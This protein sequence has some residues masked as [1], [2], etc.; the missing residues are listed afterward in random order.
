MA[1]CDLRLVVTV[2]CHSTVNSQRSQGRQMTNN[3][4][5]GVPGLD[6]GLIVSVGSHSDPKCKVP[7]LSHRSKTFE[8]VKVKRTRPRT[9]K[10]H[11]ACGLSI[12]ARGSVWTEDLEVTTDGHHL[13]ANRVP[14]T[15]FTTKQL[16]ELEK[17]FHF[18]KYLTRARRVDISSALQLSETQV[19]IWF[20][21]RLMKHKKLT[22]EGLLLPVTPLASSR[23]S[24]RSRSNNLDT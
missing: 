8:W 2:I 22:R 19:K 6:Q 3:E 17:D 18:N 11:M 23:C 14:R 13:T 15:N 5:D 12:V 21:N 10:M 4:S 24:E 9:A 20:Q 7:E 16:T 1:D